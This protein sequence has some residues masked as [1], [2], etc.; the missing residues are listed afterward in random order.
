MKISDIPSKFQIPFA[1]AAG[2]GF[3]RP[4]PEA[5][6]IGIQNGAAS[7]T[8]GFPP[9][10]FLPVGAGGVPPFGQ[11]M[12]GILNQSTA[13]NRWQ[14]AGA[15][16]VYDASLSTA[17]GGYPKGALLASATTAGLLW[18]NT[19][20]D[21]TTNPDSAGSNW[22]GIANIPGVQN[23]AWNWAATFGGTT[24]ALTATLA[25]VPT[26]LTA[27]LRVQGIAASNNNGSSAS[28]LNVNSL[29]AK[30]IV[31][32]GGGNPSW[33]TGDIL[34]FVYNGTA[35]FLTTQSSAQT[36]AIVPTI[37]T[38]QVIGSVSVLIPFNTITTLGFSA[39]TTVFLDPSTTYS[40]GVLTVGP[41]DAG[42]WS[43]S[44]WINAQRTDS[45]VLWGYIY[46]NGSQ[47][48]VSGDTSASAGSP[49]G[50]NA[51]ISI[52]LRLNSGDNIQGRVF[53]QNA[54]SNSQTI[55]GNMGLI[56]MSA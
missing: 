37:Q 11:D 1:N 5:S 43:V 53:Q 41:K 47:Y 46:K 16:V 2:G 28:S 32:S 29:G 14:G 17:I 13:W 51:T 23:D 27:G 15:Q 6:Q 50:M 7:L 35:F 39:S 3:I 40:G 30:S 54:S 36:A 45:T 8:D 49:S 34:S 52:A 12:N 55:L 56:R 18:L 33:S 38:A 26:A 20:D 42:T 9:L 25:P 22:V 19:V 10:N 31:V 21:N 44:F 24:T 48:A 4:I